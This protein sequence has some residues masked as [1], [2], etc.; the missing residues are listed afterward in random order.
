M[1]RKYRERKAGKEARQ[2]KE[3]MLKFRNEL[4]FVHTASFKTGRI[5]RVD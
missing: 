2:T 5:I 4:A 3:N 1:N